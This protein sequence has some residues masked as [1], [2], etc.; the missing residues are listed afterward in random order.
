VG[1][2]GER[3]RLEVGGR[4]WIFVGAGGMEG[5]KCWWWDWGWGG[6]WNRGNGVGGGG[7]RMEDI[8]TVP[9]YLFCPFS[10]A[11][12]KGSTADKVCRQ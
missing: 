7:W 5:W 6:G 8:G 10:R 11:F 9:G 1:E 12:F 4:V 2:K 3:V